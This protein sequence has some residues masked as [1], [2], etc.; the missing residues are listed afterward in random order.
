M[1]M[2]LIFMMLVFGVG[3]QGCLLTPDYQAIPGVNQT[4]QVETNFS[5]VIS[6][7]NSIVSVEVDSF[8][9]SK[10]DYPSVYIGLHNSDDKTASVA[11][12][13]IRVEADGQELIVKD[14]A[15]LFDERQNRLARLTILY[16]GHPEPRQRNRSNRTKRKGINPEFNEYNND[17]TRYVE[18]QL[19]DNDI[20]PNT[21]YGGY[22]AFDRLDRKVQHYRV[23]IRF[24]DEDHVFIITRS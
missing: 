19:M 14:P 1:K 3:L 17:Y 2:R 10:F 24:N 23:T 9:D 6:H 16:N 13:D 4:A 18:H 12:D 5:R 7:K 11:L 20:E 21:S 22:I 15:S 8:I